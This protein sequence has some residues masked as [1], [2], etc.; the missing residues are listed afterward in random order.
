MS[1]FSYQKITS[2]LDSR[3]NHGQWWVKCSSSIGE[4]VEIGSNNFRK[5]V[6]S[7]SFSLSFFSQPKPIKM[8]F[9]ILRKWFIREINIKLGYW[10]HINE[11]RWNQV[12]IWK[13]L[14]ELWQHFC[15]L[16]AMSIFYL[17]LYFLITY[18]KI[19][20]LKNYIINRQGINTIW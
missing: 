16:K 13:T 18:F 17:S 11:W 5:E 6:K 20:L 10:Y 14:W 3:L 2:Y 12:Y 8:V 1:Q 15:K 7:P 19:K 4:E 9:D